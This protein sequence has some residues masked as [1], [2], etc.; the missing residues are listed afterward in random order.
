M[1]VLMYGV[2]EYTDYCVCNNMIDFS[3]LKPVTDRDYVHGASQAHKNP[4]RVLESTLHS[5]LVP[6]LVRIFLSELVCG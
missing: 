2:L 1:I 3:Q 5:G 6:T 4:P